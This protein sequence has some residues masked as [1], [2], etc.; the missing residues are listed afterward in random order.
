MGDRRPRSR[1][2]RIALG[3]LVAGVLLS[4][5]AIALAMAVEPVPHPPTPSPPIA[6]ADLPPRPPRYLTLEQLDH[7]ARL[8][9]WPEGRGW[10]PEMR[11]IIQC[12]T[13][14]L[15]THAYNPHDPNGGSF[16]L[17]QLNG[18]YHFDRSGE[19]FRRWADPVVNLRVALWLRT[20]LG[21]FGSL[22]GWANCAARLGIH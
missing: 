8:A 1:P 16:G 22:G 10:W 12:E 7:Y 5:A 13:A 3:F 9:G 2:A 21:R 19:D 14:L 20:V 11:R 18:R 4:W 17:A 15:D 6:V